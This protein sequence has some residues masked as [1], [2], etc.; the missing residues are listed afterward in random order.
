[1][2]QQGSYSNLPGFPKRNIATCIILSIVTCG[3]YGI[4]W[5][6][7]LVNDCNAASNEVNDTSGGMVFL[8]GIV[9]CGIYTLYWLYKAGGKLAKANRIRNRQNITNNGVLYLILAIF[10][11]SIVSFCLIQNE[12]NTLNEY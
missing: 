3:I 10:Q 5:F 8:L 11:L 12:L 1:M 6:I 9:T 7:C 4:Y 2:Y